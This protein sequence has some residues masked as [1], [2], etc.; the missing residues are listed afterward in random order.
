[1][2]RR[3]RCSFGYRSIQICALLP[4]VRL[5]P[6]CRRPIL[7]ATICQIHMRRCTRLLKEKDSTKA[8]GLH[9]STALVYL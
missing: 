1:M 2:G 9:F 3:P 7:N 8:R 6:P 4:P 5:G